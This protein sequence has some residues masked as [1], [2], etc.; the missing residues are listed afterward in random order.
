MPP[1]ATKL[2]LSPCHCCAATKLP[3]PPPPPPPQCCYH[4]RQVAA[5]AATTA[6]SRRCSASTTATTAAAAKLPPPPPCCRH[7]HQAATAATASCHPGC[8]A[9]KQALLPHCHQAAT[10]TATAVALWHCRRRCR[11]HPRHRYCLRTAN[12][13]T[14]LPLQCHRCGHAA[15]KLPPLLPPKW[16]YHAATTPVAATAAT[17]TLSLPPPCC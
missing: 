2:T 7:L 12:A 3:P 9:A 1:P 10:A 6:P 15:T 5:P 17:A 11:C 16:P 8:A 14:N 13:T 4:G